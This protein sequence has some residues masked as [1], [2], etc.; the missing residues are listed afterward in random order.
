MLF[1]V[2]AAAGRTAVGSCSLLAGVGTEIVSSKG[3]GHLVGTPKEVHGGTLG[4]PWRGPLVSTQLICAFL[5]TK[6]VVN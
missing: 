2:E 3:V 6:G 5:V 4:F 1:T